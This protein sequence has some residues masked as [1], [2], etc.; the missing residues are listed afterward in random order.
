MPNKLPTPLPS[1]DPIGQISESDAKRLLE[2]VKGG[3]VR[4]VVSAL[5]FFI[6]KAW[7][8]Y[9]TDQGTTVSQGARLVNVVGYQ[10]Q[11]AAIP[12]TDLAPGTITGGLYQIQTLLRQSQ[13]ATVSA[14]FQVTVTTTDHGTPIARAFTAVTGNTATTTQASTFM[15]YCDAGTPVT[16]AVSYSS[17]GATEARYYAYFRLDFITSIA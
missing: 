1:Q 10:D 14:S 15:V 3:D 13:A 16:V 9:L 11:A 17:T 12:T 5:K 6:S 2:A 7:S 4:A 8:E